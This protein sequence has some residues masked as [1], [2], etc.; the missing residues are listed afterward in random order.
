[1]GVPKSAFGNTQILNE[2]VS[3]SPFFYLEY[4]VTTFF[5]RKMYS[6]Y[7]PISIIKDLKKKIVTH[8]SFVRQPSFWDFLLHAFQGETESFVEYGNME[9]S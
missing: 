4:K 7:Y 6:T 8:F 2:N 1:M 5:N 3:R 9:F